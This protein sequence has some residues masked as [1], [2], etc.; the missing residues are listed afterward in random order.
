M[1]EGNWEVELGDESILLKTGDS[2]THRSDIPHCLYDDPRKNA[3]VLRW[4]RSPISSQQK[5]TCKHKF[6]IGLSKVI[7]FG[8]LSRYLIGIPLLGKKPMGLAR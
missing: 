3:T 7:C 1:L 2:I 5:E 8:I 6:S 4:T